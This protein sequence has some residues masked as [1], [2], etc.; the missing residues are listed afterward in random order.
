MT[1]IPTYSIALLWLLSMQVGCVKPAPVVPKPI[2][3]DRAYL[4]APNLSLQIPGLS[5]CNTSPDS[6]IRLNSNEPVNIIVHGCKSSAGLFR[7]LAQVFA[8]H[9][10]QTVCFSYNYRDSLMKSSAELNHALNL[11]SLE[12]KNSQ[13]T[14]I[15]HSQ[16]GLISRKALIKEREDK[17]TAQ[18]TSMRLVTI[19]APYAGIKAADHC[20]SPNARFFS[21]GLVI[22]ICRMIS[23]D[24]WYEITHPSPFIQ[25]PGELLEQVTSHLKIVTNETGSCRQYDQNG[26]CVEDDFVFSIDEQY[27]EPV[28][29]LPR[30]ENIE[31][32]AGHVEI[33]GNYHV[34]PKKLIKLLQHNG[35]M[36]TTP[37]ALQDQL[38]ILLSR[39]YQD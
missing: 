11:L 30:V 15:G 32:T 1:N 8:L 37:P 6:T 28:D 38:A 18:N 2:S 5:P 35:I 29:A 26:N 20:A 31:I 14:V 33:V 9:G 12:M 36:N 7:S 4:P 24:K 34:S 25:Q 3:I 16:G 39:L 27:F 10:Q 22:P 19:S 17:F 21:I 13:M 23:G